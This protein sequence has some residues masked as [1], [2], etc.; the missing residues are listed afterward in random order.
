MRDWLRIHLIP[1]SNGT[2][3]YDVFIDEVALRGW[4]EGLAPTIER[5]PHNARFYFDDPTG[6]LVLVEPH[7]NGR[8]LDIDT[9][10][11]RFKQQI[12]TGNRS[13]PLAITDLV[14]TVHSDATA[15]ELGITELIGERSFSSQPH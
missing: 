5:Q 6:E 7:T 2:S 12:A 1:G 15:A 10:I 3:E 11:D 4:L 9:T 13:V 14:P 8:E